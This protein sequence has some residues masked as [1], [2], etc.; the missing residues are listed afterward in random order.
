MSPNP[1]DPS[2][3]IRRR[4]DRAAVRR[5]TAALPEPT[6]E[7]RNALPQNRAYAVLD[8]SGLNKTQL[9][10]YAEQ[11]VSAEFALYGLSVFSPES[12]DRG[13][14]LVVRNEGGDRYD[15]RVKAVRGLNY[16]FLRQSVFRLVPPAY[17]ALV[18]FLERQKPELYLI[19]SFVWR[20]PNK[21]FVDKEYEGWKCEPEWGIRLSQK[22][23]T[24]LRRY[25]FPDV[26]C[27]LAAGCL[28]PAHR[29]KPLRAAIAT[30]DLGSAS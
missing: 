3:D 18:L 20:E 21:L 13:I 23:I 30:R 26:V 9:G 29:P 6:G 11:L 25:T 16:V 28:P 7:R 4:E 19:P 2:A 1:R 15:V 8:P 5:S 12:D 17:L 22:T 24:L 27:L 10:R 14:D